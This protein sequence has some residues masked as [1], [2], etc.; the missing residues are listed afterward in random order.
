MEKAVSRMALRTSLIYAITAAV[1][2]AFSDRLVGVLFPDRSTLTWVHTYKGFGFVII[3][4]CL[5][6]S[7][8][9]SNMRRIEKEALGRRKAE[10]ALQASETLYRSM[11]EEAVDGFFQSTT[12]GRFLRVNK[13]LADM[14]GYSSPEEMIDRVKDIG[15]QHY[16]DPH[17]RESFKKIL[18]EQGV[19]R[20]FEHEVLRKDGS[21]FWTG[22]SARVVRDEEDRILYFEG[23]HKN[24]DQQK[25]A[26]K[27]LADA[28]EQYRSLF[29]YST[30]AILIRD[31]EGLI[32]MVNEA[33]LTLLGAAGPA[34]LMGKRYLDLVH[35]EDRAVSVQRIDLAFASALEQ[36]R[37]GK[38]L[39]KILVPREH[40]MV[41]LD[42]KIV[43]VES[44]GVV[45][46][47]KKD[48][49]IQGIFRDITEQKRAGEA[50]QLSEA[51]AKR[52]S[53]E[54]LSLARIGR[55]VSSTLNIDEV[56]EG[57]VRE[58]NRLIAFDGI[59]VNIINPG[60]S[61]VSIPYVSG[62][63]IPGCAKGD[64]L[65]LGGSVTGKVMDTRSSVIIQLEDPETARQFTTL[66]GMF[67]A[68]LRSIIAVP[69]IAEDMVIGALH[70]RSCAP[71]AYAEGDLELAEKVGLQISGAIAN[72]Q[73]FEKQQKIEAALRES[74][75]RYRLVAENVSDVI[76]TRDLSLECTYISPS[77]E[78]MTGYPPEEAKALS[79][80][81][82]YTPETLARN[83]PI[84]QEELALEMEGKRDPFGVRS[85][86]F[87]GY[88][89]N[90]T[91]LW[92]ESRITFTRDGQGRINGLQG[93]SRDITER[94][95]AEEEKVRLEA[96]LVRSQK[97]EALGLLAG[98]VA[99]DLNNVLSGIVSYPDLLLLDLPSDSPLRKPILT[100]QDSGQK[101]ASI[102]QDLLTLA[103][104]GVLHKEI[105]NLNDIVL[106]YLRSPEHEKL[107]TFH[108]D[109][110]I[111]LDLEKDLPN[112]EGSTIH[113]RK[114]IMNLVSNAAEAQT[115]GGEI[116]ITS[117]RRY[118]DTPFKGYETIREGDYAILCVQDRGIGISPE[119]LGR[120][121]EPFYTK[122]VMGRSGTG[123]GMAV[124]WGTVQDH[125]GYIHV[126]STLGR[127][128]L[129][130]LSFPITG[131][132][133]VQERDGHSLEP[134]KGNGEH[135][136]VVDDIPEQREISV[137]MLKRMGY[138]ATAVAGGEEA[139]EYLKDHRADIVLLDMIMEPGIDGLETFKR[140]KKMLPGQKAVLASGF[141]ETDR[142]AE[143]KK[144]GAGAYIKKPYTLKKLGEVLKLE[145]T[146]HEA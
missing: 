118:L 15:R 142:V 43:H 33:A 4:A 79:L 97:M 95:K 94:K 136:L 145:L 122:K 135:V 102:V 83:L 86:E 110:T 87:E 69:L 68:G 17:G 56:Y 64:V 96:Q 55:I 123:L 75:E 61:V 92:T 23:T 2:I 100:I 26:E 62:I 76:W 91:K 113:L 27:L 50:L 105:V 85:L 11:V 104:R 129:F 6:Y 90:G 138:E 44:T 54:N 112:L 37:S 132:E 58:V 21:T 140:M 98:G 30:N 49:F 124:V 89:K 8:L 106:D 40:R 20:N 28:E 107:I 137:Q 66:S 51:E 103:R 93:V 143:A 127:G 117:R 121:F 9:I 48:F 35:S 22:V 38:K 5:L 130:E 131:K 24:I 119:D 116:V 16:T 81:Q 80:D 53:N 88:H 42:G 32:T 108:P 74:E 29:E 25:T 120:I 146:R 39:T 1:Y 128:T 125:K 41:R 34:D 71:Q 82:A 45:F 46:P 12:E 133:L 77:V 139:L 70:L 134:Y 67:E 19:A 52:L 3:T 65:P 63:T 115:G 59:A 73:L 31:R 57:F 47:Y 84:F 144:L 72:A 13:A 14:C 101:A 10:D 78:R 126:E 111:K 18:L 60:E 114:S 7:L 99:H 109:I 36:E 141:S